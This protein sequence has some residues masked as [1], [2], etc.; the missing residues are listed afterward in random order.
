LKYIIVGSIN[1]IYSPT[2]TVSKCQLR[3]IGRHFIQF[4]LI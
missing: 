3:E 2:P 4:N 1:I